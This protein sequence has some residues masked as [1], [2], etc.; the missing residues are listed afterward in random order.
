MEIACHISVVDNI[1]SKYPT[2]L[3]FTVT[4]LQGIYHIT[5]WCDIVISAGSH[6][7]LS[8]MSKLLLDVHDAI[9]KY[10]FT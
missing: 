3:D 7:S 1:A 2:L 6:L 4:Q 9:F 10:N 8:N 5:V